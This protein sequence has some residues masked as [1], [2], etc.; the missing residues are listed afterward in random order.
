MSGK[1]TK[2]FRKSVVRPFANLMKIFKPVAIDWS[3]TKPF[4]IKLC[5]AVERAEK[6]RKIILHSNLPEKDKLQIADEILYLIDDLQEL[7][8]IKLTEENMIWR[9]SQPTGPWNGLY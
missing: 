4:S 9:A 6:A 7:Q 3:K 5:E 1:Q 8:T 2:R